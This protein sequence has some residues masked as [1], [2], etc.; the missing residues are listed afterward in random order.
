MKACGLE[1]RLHH[2]LWGEGIDGDGD[3][4]CA[5]EREAV[6][7]AAGK[8]GMVGEDGA[9]MLGALAAGERGGEFDFEVNENCAGDGEEQ[10]ASGGVLDGAASKGQDQGVVGG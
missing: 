6:V 3:V 7:I 4:G 2:L 5:V 9:E 1:D 8:I 10:R